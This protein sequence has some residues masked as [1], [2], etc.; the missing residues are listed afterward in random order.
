[1]GLFR[2]KFDYESLLWSAAATY[3]QAIQALHYGMDGPVRVMEWQT[4]RLREVV[5]TMSGNDAR[6]V[7]LVAIFDYHFPA[8]KSGLAIPHL[9]ITDR[10]G[11][12]EILSASANQ[13][14]QGFERPLT[15]EAAVAIGVEVAK[16]LRDRIPGEPSAD[17]SYETGVVLA[18]AMKTLFDDGQT[19]KRSERSVTMSMGA[20][21]GASWATRVMGD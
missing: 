3:G 20:E 17:T 15:Q 13:L 21:M 11:M 2:R 8:G 7:G 12:A 1:M 4:A 9:P 19:L 5:E 14:I 10:P 6:S 18:L 16:S